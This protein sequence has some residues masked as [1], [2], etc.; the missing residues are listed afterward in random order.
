MSSEGLCRLRALFNRKLLFGLPVA[1]CYTSA[2]A[3]HNEISATA[4]RSRAFLHWHKD[5]RWLDEKGAAVGER[6]HLDA[7]EIADAILKA[8]NRA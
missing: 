3:L 8:L 1:V 7:A 4:C 2:S 5:S 6:N